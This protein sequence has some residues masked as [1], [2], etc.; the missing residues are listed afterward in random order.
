MYR[1]THAADRSQRNVKRAVRTARREAKI[2]AISAAAGR[3]LPW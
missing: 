3:K 1:T 2:A